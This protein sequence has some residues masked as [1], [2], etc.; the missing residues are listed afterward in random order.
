MY[1]LNL[2]GSLFHDEHWTQLQE[3]L[4]FISTQYFHMWVGKHASQLELFCVFRYNATKYKYLVL[5]HLCW[6]TLH[7]CCY[8]DAT[9]VNS[10]AID[11]LKLG[12]QSVEWLLFAYTLICN[13]CKLC[14]LQGCAAAHEHKEMPN[15]SYRY[16][17]TLKDGCLLGSC[18]P[19]VSITSF[20]AHVEGRLTD[21]AYRIGV[22]CHW[23]SALWLAV[24]QQ[25]WAWKHKW[26]SKW[27]V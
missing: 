5:S 18:R 10:C 23:K 3:H 8:F 27:H 20:L 22:C 17:T 11:Q 25:I 13:T 24:Q 12:L 14:L 26:I 15:N 19:S 6:S 9:F 16:S 7:Y 2:I 4:V 21:S 1:P